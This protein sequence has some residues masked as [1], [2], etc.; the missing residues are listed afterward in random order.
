MQSEEGFK[1]FEEHG[2][3]ERSDEKMGFGMAYQLICPL[4]NI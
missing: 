1:Q 2:N 4:G 3:H